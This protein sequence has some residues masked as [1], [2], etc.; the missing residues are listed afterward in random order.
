M[1]KKIISVLLCAAMSLS[2]FTVNIF[3][4]ETILEPLSENEG[5]IE[6]LRLIEPVK[7]NYGLTD[8]DLINM[9]VSDPIKTYEY[10]S[11]GLSFLR[12]YIPLISGNGLSAWAIEDT[13]DDEVFYQISTAYVDEINK[14]VDNTTQF[15]LIY[16]QNSCYLFD[17]LNLHKLGSFE[18]IDDRLILTENTLNASAVELNS[19]NKT[20]DLGYTHKPVAYGVSLPV[21]TY[22]CN[23]SYVTQNGYS[24]DNLCWAASIACIANYVKGY[25]YTALNVFLSHVSSTDKY[26]RLPY[27]KEVEV[28]REYA[29]YYQCK[30]YVPSISIIEKNIQNGY[31]LYGYFE[32]ENG[33][34]S[35]TIYGCSINNQDITLSCIYIMDPQSDFETARYSSGT[36]KY[37]SGH[38]GVELKLSSTTCRY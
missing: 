8:E 29:L 5:I 27:G 23:V 3:A 18:D 12:N 14:T 13:E 1:F 2:L 33:A 37:E 25:H 4:E 31:P 28:L 9:R 21:D 34:H 22:M 30:G 15:V 24:Y 35:C 17:G 38:N 19:L 10:T 11:G 36:Y 20:C 26:N 7:E 16:D 6:A 32:Y